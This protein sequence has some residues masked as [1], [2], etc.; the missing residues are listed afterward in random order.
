MTIINASQFALRR[1]CREL[2]KANESGDWSAIRHWDLELSRYLDNA[3]SDE[4]RDTKVLISE[5]ENI[6][7]TYGRVVSSLAENEPD[8]W[9][10][11]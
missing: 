2:E 9:M 5:M 11:P 4:N 6:L 7:S 8:G 3:F 10:A 1:A